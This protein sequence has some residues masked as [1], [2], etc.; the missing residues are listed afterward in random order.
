MSW[1]VRRRTVRLAKQ[2]FVSTV[3]ADRRYIADAISCAKQ[4]VVSWLYGCLFRTLSSWR[5]FEFFQRNVYQ[6]FQFL[7]FSS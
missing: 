4:Y 3:A 2:I 5:D 6:N 7:G 1:I